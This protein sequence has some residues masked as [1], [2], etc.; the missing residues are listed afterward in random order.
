MIGRLVMDPSNNSQSVILEGKPRDWFT[1]IAIVR[2]DVRRKDFPTEDAFIAEN[3]C[4]A[5]SEQVAEQIRKLGVETTVI[6]AD[7]NLADSLK[8]QQPDLCINFVDTMHGSGSAASG[9][10]GLF[11]L[12]Q[13]PYV[14]AGTLALA[15]N[16]NK[17]LTRT[18][19]EAWEIPTPQCQLFR[20]ASQELEYD[21]RFPLI[22]K[23]NEEHGS[24]GID[25]TSVVTNNK[26]LK[27]RVGWLIS[28]YKQP[29]LAEEFIENARELTGVVLEATQRKVMLSERMFEAVD[30][31]FRILT[32]ATKWAT[33]LGKEE[34]VEYKAVNDLDRNL[35]LRIKDNLR[36]AF[37]VLRMDDLARFDVMLD[38]YHNH[39]VVDC[40]AN[41]SLGPESSV[42][43]AVMANNQRFETVLLNIL[44]R[45]RLDKLEKEGNQTL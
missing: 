43:R 21:L 29:V 20:S 9:I 36:T 16:N 7:S 37:E 31:E 5:R 24:V 4:I 22:V 11:E 2:T 14:G 39:Y 15:L 41:P 19:L 3:E 34:P 1:K 12:L 6:V 26:A 18:L 33:D 30:S 45:N 25:A 44:Q 42:A 13:I 35:I 10:P 38:K 28:T 27:E 40:N 8:E 17:Y 23:L 32:F